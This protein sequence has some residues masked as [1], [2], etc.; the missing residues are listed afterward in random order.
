MCGIRA[1]TMPGPRRADRPTQAWACPC[2]VRARIPYRAMVR[3]DASGVEGVERATS[4]S[5]GK[6]DG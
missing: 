5:H 3:Q 1:E 2:Y 4:P 6:Q